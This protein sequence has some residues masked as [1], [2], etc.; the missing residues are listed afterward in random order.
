MLFRSQMFGEWSWFDALAIVSATVVLV[1][2][3]KRPS[4]WMTFA[5]FGYVAGVLPS[6]L[7]WEGV[8]H[9][10]RSIG[11]L[12]FLCV[13]VGGTIATLAD[14]A[15]K[16]RR[17]IPIT[18]AGVAFVFLAAFLPV[19]FVDYPPRAADMFDAPA[20]EKLS[21]PDLARMLASPSEEQPVQASAYPTLAIQYYELRAGAIR[22]ERK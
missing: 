9:A 11:A 2:R 6:A 21:Q 19:F 12:P 22:C 3:R 4:G 16:A 14:A 20:A 5:A 15:V 17:F 13:L 18:A 7:T 8:P 10:L 1:R